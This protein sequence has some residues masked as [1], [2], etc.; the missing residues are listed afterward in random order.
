MQKFVFLHLRVSTKC[1]VRVLAI[2]CKILEVCRSTVS[3]YC[4]VRNGWRKPNFH[5]E[6]TQINNYTVVSSLDNFNNALGLS[7]SY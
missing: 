2:S 3:K 6:F 5:L 1:I 4:R 7:D